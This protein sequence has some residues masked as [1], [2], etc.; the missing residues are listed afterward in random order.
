MMIRQ[1]WLVKT[2]ATANDVIEC[3]DKNK[4]EANGDQRTASS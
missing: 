3:S 4:R 2:P 1:E